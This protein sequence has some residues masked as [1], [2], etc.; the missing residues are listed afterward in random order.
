[1][2]QRIVLRLQVRVRII[3]LRERYE[4]D[5]PSLNSSLGSLSSACARRVACSAALASA[6][7]CTGFS[8][9]TL[10]AAVAHTHASTLHG[11]RHNSWS[12]TGR[13]KGPTGT[14]STKG[15]VSG[16]A[17]DLRPVPEVEAGVNFRQDGGVRRQVAGS[18]PGRQPGTGTRQV[19]EGAVT[20]SLHP[21][22]PGYPICVTWARIG[23]Q[24]IDGLD[25]G[26]S[27]RTV[28]NLGAKG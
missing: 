23:H 7:V 13:V 8:S 25:E 21:E 26:V 11:A 24:A 1:M 20:P 9:L 15:G 6:R 16:P 27:N 10:S 2:F 5:F 14:R 17:E 12:D 22:V 19:R 18:L 3:G 4:S 28:G